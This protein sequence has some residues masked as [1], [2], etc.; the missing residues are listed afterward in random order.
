MQADAASPG[1]SETI[2]GAPDATFAIDA[3]QANLG[4][5]ELG[6]LAQRKADR[7]DVKQFASRM[8]ADHTKG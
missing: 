2:A 4:E 7:P 5:I 8:V 1:K 6:T 3:A